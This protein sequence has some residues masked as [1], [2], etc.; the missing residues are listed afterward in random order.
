[1]RA[2]SRSVWS[3]RSSSSLT[4]QS[5]YSVQPIQRAV[6]EKRASA[7]LSAKA[8]PRARARAPSRCHGA[9]QRGATKSMPVPRG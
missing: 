2:M 3:K 1:M 9:G 4:L 6:V 7:R 8:S 5:W